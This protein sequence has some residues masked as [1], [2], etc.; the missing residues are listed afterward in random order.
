MLSGME[1]LTVEHV[2][3]VLRS[4]LPEARVRTF[5]QSTATSELAAAAIGCQVAQ[6]AKSI[7]FV[8]D[9]EP[10]LVV[11]SGAA[12]VDD[13][14]LARLLG[15][16]RRKIKIA[17]PEQCVACFGYAPGGVPPFGHRRNDVR[18]FVDESLATL[19]PIYAAAGSPNTIF[20]ID[21]DALVRIT[22]G[23]VAELR[24]QA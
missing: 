18:I 23:T 10:V 14:K 24:R 11:T 1:P 16:G 12:R 17:N 5:D 7:G 15:I 3:D 8:V 4:H 2:R 19:Q 22:G 13:R 21:F 9:G 20:A 6:I